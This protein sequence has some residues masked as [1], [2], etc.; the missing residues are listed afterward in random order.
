VIEAVQRWDQLKIEF[1]RD[2]VTHVADEHEKP[3][4]EEPRGL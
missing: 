2:H 1:I 4:P 3:E